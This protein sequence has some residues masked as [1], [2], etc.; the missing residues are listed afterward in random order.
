MLEPSGDICR[1]IRNGHQQMAP[2]FS[3]PGYKKRA[4]KQNKLCNVYTCTYQYDQFILFLF[5]HY[6]VSLL[7]N[8]T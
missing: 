1:C 5:V 7:L 6:V 4:K 3:W 2:A 8:L